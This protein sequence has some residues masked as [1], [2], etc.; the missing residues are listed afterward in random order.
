MPSAASSDGIIAANAFILE[1]EG[2][3]GAMW[4][5][6]WSQAKI[7]LRFYNLES[8]QS[9]AITVI[10]MDNLSE[11]SKL[12]SRVF[13]GSR[14][15]PHW[16]LTI[17]KN[18]APLTNTNSWIHQSRW[19]ESRS[20]RCPMELGDVHLWKICGFNL[21]TRALLSLCWAL[22]QFRTACKKVDRAQVL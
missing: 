12:C 3:L 8:G 21:R 16:S 1:W 2:R 18:Y 4:R 22:A 7:R 10:M 5:S 14:H 15:L 6:S 19:L 9:G 13:K 17:I 11:K 20:C